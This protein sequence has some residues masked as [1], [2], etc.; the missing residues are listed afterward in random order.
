LQKNW[1]QRELNSVLNIEAS[2]GILKVLPLL[3]GT[4]IER[5]RIIE[6]YPLMNDK[7]YMRWPEDSE[8]ILKQIELLRRRQHPSPT[9]VPLNTPT[10]NLESSTQR[11]IYIPQRV[12]NPSDKEKRDFISAGF[13][14]VTDYFVQGSSQL[15][16][17]IDDVD[18]DFQVVHT[19][20]IVARLY[21][22]GKE[23]SKCKIWTGGFFDA[24]QLTYSSSFHSIDDDSSYNDAL[25]VAD[26]ALVWKPSGINIL[27]SYKGD[28]MAFGHEAASEYLWRL[29]VRPL[30]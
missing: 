21:K 2:T 10:T 9:I 16:N 17:S 5:A 4:D 7:L 26:N 11:T 8:N 20:K 24:S 1:P 13:K 18:V 27:S 6:A 30:E 29:F 25:R 12:S 15:S 14:I 23:I 28:P 22:D 3:V 19:D